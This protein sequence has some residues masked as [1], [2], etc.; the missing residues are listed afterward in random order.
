MK[1]QLRRVALNFA[2]YFFRICPFR[3]HTMF[4]IA[5]GGKFIAGFAV[6]QSKIEKLKYRLPLTAKLKTSGLKLIANRLQNCFHFEVASCF[7]FK[8]FL[9]FFCFAIFALYSRMC[10]LIFSLSSLVKSDLQAIWASLFFEASFYA[11][12]KNC[13]IEIL[14]PVVKSDKV[15]F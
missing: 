15:I 3:L 12:F 6:N 14:W 8:N 1:L 9:R 11:F 5:A 10:W 13:L 4:C 7:I 2:L